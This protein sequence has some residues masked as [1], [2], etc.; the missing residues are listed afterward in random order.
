MIDVLCTMHRSGFPQD[1]LL[2]VIAASN[3]KSGD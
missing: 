1:A 2:K 3:A